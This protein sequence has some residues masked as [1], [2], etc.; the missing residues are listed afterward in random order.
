MKSQGFYRVSDV[1]QEFGV[2]S[3]CVRK[4]IKKGKIRV[5]TT[6]GGHCRIRQ[7]DFSAF[8]NRYKE[9]TFQTI[10]PE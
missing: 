5:F 6:P 9:I 1:A 4:W 2:T 10:N 8:I 3:V 7:E